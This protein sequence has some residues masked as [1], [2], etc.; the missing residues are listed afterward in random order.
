MSLF[1]TD[2]MAKRQFVGLGNYINLL[3]DGTFIHAFKNNI[4]MVI[5][6]LI[7]HMPLAMFFAN[8]IFKKIKGSAF[9]RQS[10]FCRA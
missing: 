2:L 4:F 7:A 1:N 5:G 10:F 8:A 3:K 6:S 9:F